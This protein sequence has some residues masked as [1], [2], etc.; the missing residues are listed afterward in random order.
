VF[1]TNWRE[2]NMFRGAL[3]VHISQIIYLILTFKQSSDVGTTN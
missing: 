3:Y 1:Y 2:I